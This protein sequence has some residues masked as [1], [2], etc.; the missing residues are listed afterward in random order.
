MFRYAARETHVSKN[1]YTQYT[2]AALA[3][4]QACYALLL[5]NVVVFPCRLLK[6]LEHIIWSTRFPN[7]VMKRDFFCWLRG[8]SH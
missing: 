2:H 4:S 1:L 5:I 7:T 3:F 8:F 6:I